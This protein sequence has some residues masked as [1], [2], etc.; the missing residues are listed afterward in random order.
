MLAPMPNEPVAAAPRSA[1]VRDWRGLLVGVALSAVLGIAAVALGNVAWLQ[2]HGFSALAVAI[3]LGILL[4]NTLYPRYGVL[5]EPG[6]NFSKQRVLRL[7]IVLYGLRLTLQDVAA[8]G[9]GGILVDAIMVC[10][11]FLLSC[12]IGERWLGLDRRA[13]MLIGV[14]SAICGAA[15][16]M[17]AEPVVRARAEQVTVAVATVVGF[18]T[19]AIFLY[20]LLYTLNQ[21]ALWVP[22]GERGFGIYIGSTVHEVAQVVAAAQS[23]GAAAGGSAVIAKMVRVM[24]LAPFLIGLSMWLA[25]DAAQRDS[26][27]ARPRALAHVP[28]FAV[29]FIAVVL[30][31]S[32]GVLPAPLVAQLTLFD[33]L[34]LAMAMAALGLTTRAS[35]IV[36]AGPRPLLLALLLFG[37]LVA[38]GALVN[39]GVMALFATG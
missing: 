30:V 10:S 39:R 13:A 22:G 24:M 28:W 7:A 32:L 5:A 16:V 3:A 2:H 4:G 17:G 34:L 18:G 35:A 23:I 1:P 21:D 37:W 8:V 19:V 31:N 36:R 33:T 12:W 11:T 29:G 27:G 20:P 38:G 14:G 26:H 25:R 9:V 15:A 6:V